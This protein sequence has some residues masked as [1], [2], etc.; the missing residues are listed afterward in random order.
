VL[1]IPRSGNAFD[2]AGIADVRLVL[3]MTAQ[4]DPALASRQRE[5][6]ADDSMSVDDAEEFA[7]L[8]VGSVA[9]PE[10]T[11]AFRVR[12]AARSRREYHVAVEGVS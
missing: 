12:S 10:T 5:V 6:L 7:V 2:L 11:D 9:A 1:T 4:Y 3:Y 8:H